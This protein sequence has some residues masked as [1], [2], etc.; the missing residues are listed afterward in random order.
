MN[1]TQVDTNPRV[2]CCTDTRSYLFWQFFSRYNSGYLLGNQKHCKHCMCVKL[3]LI[4]YTVESFMDITLW[5]PKYVIVRGHLK[6][7]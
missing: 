3:P 4:L 5:F 2:Q 6:L 7:Y 1:G